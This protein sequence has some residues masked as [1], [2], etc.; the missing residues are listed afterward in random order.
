MKSQKDETPKELL[1]YAKEL[2]DTLLEDMSEEECVDMVRSLVELL[3]NWQ[4]NIAIFKDQPVMMGVSCLAVTYMFQDA[5]VK[6]Y[7][8]S[9]KKL[10]AIQ[11][12]KKAF[13]E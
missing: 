11:S 7:D 1:A 2:A 5:F 10:D 3:A 6:A 12:L 4:P 8:H 13:Q 9:Q